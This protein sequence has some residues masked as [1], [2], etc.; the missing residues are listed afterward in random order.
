MYKNFPIT[1]TIT[2]VCCK[3]IWAEYHRDRKNFHITK[4]IRWLARKYK[5]GCVAKATSNSK[6][7]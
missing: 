1:S 6:M 4:A 7:L 5:N 2:I 3:L